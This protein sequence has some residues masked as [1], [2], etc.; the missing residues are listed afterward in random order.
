MT[1]DAELLRAYEPIIRYTNGEL[2]FPTAVE[3]YLAECDLLVGSQQGH[4]RLLASRGSVTT[5]N[6]AG[7]GRPTRRDALPAARPGAA[8]RARPGAVVAAAGATRVPGAGPAGPGRPL[9]PARRRRVQRLAAAARHGPR[10]DRGG[11]RGQVRGG[12]GPRPA[13]RL[14]RPGRAAR[15]LDRAPLPVLLLHERLALDVHGGERPRGRP[16]AGVRRPRGRP[17]RARGRS[18]SP[19]RPTTTPA[20][21][22][23]GAGTTRTIAL[24]GDHPVIHAGRRLARGLL[25]GRRV[26][27]DRARSRRPAACA[28]C[29]TGL[30]TFWRDTLR[31]D[32]P[33]DLGAR[34]RG[35]P[36]H[37]VRRL[38][39][40]RRPRDRAGRRGRRVDARSRSTT[41]SA[42]STAT[43]ACGASTR[44]TGSPAS[45]PRPA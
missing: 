2:F 8:R 21:T 3:P 31:Q 19:A 39:P 36:E 32:D 14:P 6:L 1:D 43:A 26:H 16:G 34:A 29:S 10:R 33:G 20:T 18:G 37:P 35:R 15:R 45:A 7:A 24:V 5:T 12:P 40:R 27:H 23:A 42:G 30:A 9:R 22:C 38:R 4:T 28:G 41:G 11:R 13:L 17:R 25:R 44:T